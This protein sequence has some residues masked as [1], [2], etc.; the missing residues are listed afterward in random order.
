MKPIVNSILD[1]DLYKLTM[2]MAVLEIYPD[3]RFLIGSKTG[4]NS[5]STSNSLNFLKNKLTT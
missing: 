4:E 1:T 5:V 2:Q 3:V